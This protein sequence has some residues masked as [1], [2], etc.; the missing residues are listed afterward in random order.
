MKDGGRL[1]AAIE[2]LSEIENHRRPVQAALKDWG[3]AHRFAGSKD[4]AVV[5]NV[6][7]DALRHKRS[8][9]WHMQSDT[10]RA[11]ALATYVVT[12]NQP[13]DRLNEAL[14]EDRHAPAPLTEAELQL[15]SNPARDGAP[16]A[17]LA[18]VPDW[19]WPEFERSLGEEAVAEG[20][21]LADR[22]PVDMRVN[23]LKAGRDKTLKRLG[24]LPVVPTTHSPNG[25]RIKAE[26]GMGRMPAVQVEEIY[27]KGWFELQDEASQLAALLSGAEAGNQVLDFCAGGGG[28]T[29]ALAAQMENRG[30]VYAYDADRVRLAPIHDRLSRAGARCVQVR[31]P[32]TG[33]L[34]DLK[35]SMDVVF[36]DAPCTGT[37]V[38]RR[39][40]DSK[41]RLSERALAERHEEQAKVLD[42][43]SDYVKPGGI[44]AYATCSVLKSE[45]ADQ[46]TAFMQ[47]YPEFEPV[48]ALERWLNLEGTSAD[49]VRFD[50][51]GN[52]TF[53]PLRTGT[54]GFFVA[55]LKRNS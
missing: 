9:Q 40:P 31:D 24:H 26:P 36:V 12:W 37:G 7:F 54:D 13:V 16:E 14:A 2:V 48:S 41:W 47:R 28:K 4:R 55:L 32:K 5:G 11:L 22:A 17:V 1:S 30:Q 44:L 39:R 19:L 21:R 29:L 20:Q 46:V 8:L 33:T 6:V 27:R 50:V 34:D 25:I 45:N 51:D 18:D 52:L 49:T 38:W 23:S 35:A 42:S 3:I 10:P 15:L 53:T 43:A